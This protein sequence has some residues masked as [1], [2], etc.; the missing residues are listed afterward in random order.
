MSE[1][2]QDLLAELIDFIPELIV[3]LITFGATLLA[4]KPIAKAVERAARRRIGKEET[5]HILSRIVRWT[6][7]VIGTIIALDQVNFDVTGFLAGL[8]V[9]G[10][11]IGFA[12][13]D[14]ARNFVA[15]ILLL[16]RRPFEIGDTVETVGYTGEIEDITTR[17]TVVRTLDGERVILANIDI[18]SNPITNYTASPQRRRTIYI[19]L[20]YGQDVPQALQVFQDTIAGV[21]GVLEEPA[22]SLLAEELGDSAITLAARF[23]VDPETH[24]LLD[25]HSNVVL[26][27]NAAAEREGI[28]LPYPIQTVRLVERVQA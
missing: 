2:L 15:G 20:G 23:W 16:A 4:A 25:V 18:L 7:L 11:T 28:D 26:A 3:A 9:A 1:S 5:V 17:D 14:I 22:P 10:I 24:S 19:G 12:L 27:V 13:Q 6:V 21:P 8:G